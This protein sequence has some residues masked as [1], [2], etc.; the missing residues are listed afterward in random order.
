MFSRMVLA[1]AM[2][3]A[4]AGWPG[5][6]ESASPGKASC[7]GAKSQL[8]AESKQLAADQRTFDARVASLTKQKDT[9][10]RELA[11]AQRLIATATAQKKAAG[12]ALKK[13]DAQM[14]ALAA[15]IKADP[16]SPAVPGERADY[17]DLVAAGKA[18]LQIVN[19]KTAS[20][21]SYAKLR[22][23]DLSHV[24]RFVLLL[25][26]D[27]A[28]TSPYR[29]R[30]ANDKI[31]M[32]RAGDFLKECAAASEGLQ[33]TWT[34]ETG[35]SF[36]GGFV[37]NVSHKLSGLMELKRPD[38]AVNNYTG[39]FGKGAAMGGNVETGSLMSDKVALR[40]HPTF[41][42]DDPNGP[43]FDNT[44]GWGSRLEFNGELSSNGHEVKG[45]VYHDSPHIECEFTMNR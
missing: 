21:K 25:E 24:N 2:L 15:D 4:T 35:C 38:P 5:E 43:S 17:N 13:I 32:K 1:S 44:H 3:I 20:L 29:K 7:E 10:T 34:F 18:P 28:P 33:G 16:L 12:A 36:S 27:E 11:V 26:R 8:A 45:N 37:P 41:Y 22:T 39:E 31:A 23:L 30:I 42:N 14:E 40:L 9:A 19:S 6:T